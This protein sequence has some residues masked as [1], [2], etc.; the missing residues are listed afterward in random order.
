[1]TPDT[2]FYKMASKQKITKVQIE[3]LELIV[4][5]LMPYHQSFNAMGAPILDGRLEE[6]LTDYKVKFG[7]D[8]REGH[9]GEGQQPTTPQA[10]NATDSE[11]K[12]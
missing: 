10:T 1:M 5:E 9:Y 11:P 7:V 12:G 3:L 2:E 6:L 4:K 8:L